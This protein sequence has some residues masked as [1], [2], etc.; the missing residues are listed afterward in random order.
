[1]W[2][3]VKYIH[4]LQDIC[5]IICAVLTWILIIYA[6]FVVTAV[7]LIPT[8]HTLYS[9]FNMA[10]FQSLAFLA[11]ASHLRTMFTD[12]VIRITLK[13]FSGNEMC[14]RDILKLISYFFYRVQYQKVM[15]QKKWYNKWDLEMG[16]LFLSVQN[17]VL[18]SQIERII[19]LFVKGTICELV[20]L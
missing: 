20:S 10:I 9:S 7:I 2:L 6:E 17:V 15:Q 18:S 19:V 3:Y 4:F 16:K 14:I 5:G 11:F 8:I 13:I 12:P 1:M